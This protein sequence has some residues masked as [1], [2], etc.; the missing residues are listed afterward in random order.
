M[1][2]VES[3]TI[4]FNKFN[5]R[6]LLKRSTGRLYWKETLDVENLYDLFKAPFFQEVK[7]KFISFLL[8]NNDNYDITE[9]LIVLINTSY[10]LD[11]TREITE[12]DLVNMIEESIQKNKNSE[13]SVDCLYFPIDLNVIKEAIEIN[14]DSKAAYG[15]FKE[16][17]KFTNEEG[18]EM[19]NIDWLKSIIEQRKDIELAQKLFE[20]NRVSYKWVNM[21]K[22]KKP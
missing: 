17:V 19:F 15:V 8:E 7:E 9:L 13:F 10:H 14:I 2:N 1:N 3:K 5:I 16:I 12:D 11:N 4:K 20:E 22:D 6:S 18:I 21:L